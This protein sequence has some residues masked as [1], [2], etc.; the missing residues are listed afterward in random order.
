MTDQNTTTNIDD[1][2]AEIRVRALG[3]SRYVGQAPYADEMMLAEIERLRIY[4]LR[5]EGVIIDK[6]RRIAAARDSLS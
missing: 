4:A 3:R 2:L 6:T 1:Y 5:L